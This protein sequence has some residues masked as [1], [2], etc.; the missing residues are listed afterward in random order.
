MKN[1]HLIFLHYLLFIIISEKA[2]HETLFREN[3][4]PKLQP[5]DAG[6]CRHR[7]QPGAAGSSLIRTEKLDTMESHYL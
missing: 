7:F 6:C 5:P 2:T 1:L 4:C 3:G